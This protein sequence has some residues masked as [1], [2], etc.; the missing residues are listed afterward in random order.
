MCIRDRCNTARV[1]LPRS[2]VNVAR[3]ACSSHESGHGSP[4]FLVLLA[5]LISGCKEFCNPLSDDHSSLVVV[6]P[7]IRGV[8]PTPDVEL[9]GRPLL[10]T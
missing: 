9:G 2:V 8:D 3:I 6:A 5:L 7:D 4:I 10:N 1:T